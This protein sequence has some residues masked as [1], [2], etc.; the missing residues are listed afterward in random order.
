MVMDTVNDPDRPEKARMQIHNYFKAT[1]LPESYTKDYT[2]KSP[3]GPTLSLNEFTGQ[4][5]CCRMVR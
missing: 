5:S 4:P 3:I 1:P 2:N